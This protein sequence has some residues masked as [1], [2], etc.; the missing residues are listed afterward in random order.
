MLFDLNR[1]LEFIIPSALRII[2]YF[3]RTVIGVGNI[4]FRIWSDI[5]L[6]LSIHY[7]FNTVQ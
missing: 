5:G 3:A 7:T 6:V 2:S 4:Q 1:A